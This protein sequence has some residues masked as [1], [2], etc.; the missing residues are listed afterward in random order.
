VIAQNKVAKRCRCYRRPNAW[1][2]GRANSGWRWRRQTAAPS[3]AWSARLW[4]A[5]RP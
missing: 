5:L 2:P 1:L 3:R 4:Q